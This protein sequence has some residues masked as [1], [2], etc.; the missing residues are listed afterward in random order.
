MREA[1]WGETEGP[2]LFVCVVA[3][4][5]ADLYALARLGM[6]LGLSLKTA[7]RAASARGRILVLPWIAYFLLTIL[8]ILRS[9]HFLESTTFL[10]GAWVVISMLNNL[11]FYTSARRNLYEQFR[12][13]ATQRF[14]SGKSGRTADRQSPE[15]LSAPELAAAQSLPSGK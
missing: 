11:C 14:D 6:W 5:V 13:V 1:S 7:Q 3:I 12:V 2:L 8:G 10:I 15:D 4:F 9:G